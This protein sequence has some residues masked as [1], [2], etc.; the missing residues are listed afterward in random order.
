MHAR[1][2]AAHQLALWLVHG[3]RVAC[4]SR[5]RKQA[6]TVCRGTSGPGDWLSFCVRF[7]SAIP[8][9]VHARLRRFFMQAMR[10]P[11]NAFRTTSG[12]DAVVEDVEGKVVVDSEDEDDLD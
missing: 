3:L 6:G 7:H 2:R 1:T 9:A 4:R 12:E 11:P 5:G 10:Y 8:F